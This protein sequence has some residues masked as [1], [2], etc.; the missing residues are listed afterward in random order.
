LIHYG[1]NSGFQA[2]NLAVLMGARRIV[3]T[4]YDMKP[5][6]DGRKH[7]HDAGAHVGGWPVWRRWIDNLATIR[8]SIEGAGLNVE[9]FNATRETAIPESIFPRVNLESVL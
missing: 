6:A 7:W 2:I 3:L 5:G 9:I 4:G 1:G 8:P